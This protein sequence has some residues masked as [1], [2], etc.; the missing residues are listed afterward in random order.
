M[1]KVLLMGLTLV[2][3]LSLA[4]CT[5]NILPA[6]TLQGSVE[7]EGGDPAV[8]AKV[9]L[10]PASAAGT[11]WVTYSD[12]AGNWT[13]GRKIRPESYT[14]KFEHADADE[15]VSINYVVAL[16]FKTYTVPL[17]TLPFTEGG[18][19]GLNVSGT[20]IWDHDD[21]PL[22]AMVPLLGA[23][24]EVDGAVT[25]SAYTDST[26]TWKISNVPAGEYDITAVKDG[27]ANGTLLNVDIEG[28]TTFVSPQI[29]MIQNE[30][31]LVGYVSDDSH[32]DLPNASVTLTPI[33]GA[34]TP[35]YSVT[36]INGDW[37]VMGAK[38]GLY[39]V[40]VEKAGYV[41]QTRDFNAMDSTA[42]TI[43]APDIML[44][45]VVAPGT[46]GAFGEV[47]WDHDANPS[48]PREPLV[49]V[50]VSIIPEGED[51]PIQIV[52]S[53]INGDWSV[54]NL[55][56]GGYTVTFEKFGMA[57]VELSLNAV[58]SSPAY[59]LGEVFMIPGLT[60]DPIAV[61]GKVYDEI[62]TPLYD[63]K[64][65][66]T[67]QFAWGYTRTTYTNEEGSFNIPSMIAGRYWMDITK[68]GYV[69]SGTY[70]IDL[71]VGGVDYDLG[72]FQI[73]AAP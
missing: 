73:V 40:K 57:T 22:T 30:V 11:S 34:Y 29:V 32:V 43:Y 36:D 54:A 44:P 62:A 63:V 64:V 56:F 59:D 21:N 47:V 51:L 49:D 2:L 61:S 48:T 65:V 68:S 71:S 8:N 37:S 6:A 17:Q 13:T 4:G 42:A 3:A 33:Y 14:I 12:A 60:T 28:T 38:A 19:T 26:G 58:L 41:T 39:S 23:S 69:S 10:T 55:P 50:K 5:I 52:F 46:A 72:T 9:T 24:V 45:V 27:W 25:K 18:T 67:P 15:S 1:K 66:F 16:P 35:L 31:D 20:V 7:F 70:E 53:D